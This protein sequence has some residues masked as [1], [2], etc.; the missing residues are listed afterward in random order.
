[1]DQNVYFDARP[2]ASPGRVTFKGKSA[3]EW[4]QLGH[5]GRSLIADPL[6]VAPA[7]GDFRLRSGSPAL[8]LGFH[9]IETREIGVRP[10]HR[11]RVNDLE[12]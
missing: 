2:G 5:D 3:A 6:F 8:K 9:P 10:K 7:K 4:Q 1:M 12:R 11:A